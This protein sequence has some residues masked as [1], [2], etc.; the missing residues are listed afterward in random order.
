MHTAVTYRATAIFGRVHTAFFNYHHFNEMTNM[1]D[2]I[3]L[4]RIMTALD[5]EFKRA[6]HF[7]DEGYENNNDYGL[8]GPVMRP[9]H[10][11]F[12]STTKT[13]F[14]PTDYKGA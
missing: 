1:S 10:I 9:V 6:L 13:S 11:Y 14:K 4:T 2:K 5:L 12:V 8:P 3:V 7:H